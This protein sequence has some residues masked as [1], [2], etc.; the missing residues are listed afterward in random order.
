MNRKNVIAIVI[1]FVFIFI[2]RIIGI[3]KIPFPII[4]IV[5]FLCMGIAFVIT[6]KYKEDKKE[7]RYLLI[8][9]ILMTLLSTIFVIA[10]VIQNNY[11]QLSDSLKPIFISVMLILFVILLIV[12]F[13]NAA[14]KFGN[15]KS[16]KK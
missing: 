12:I 7:R 5:L 9:T 2:I 16:K 10:I 8:M 6:L 3:E 1:V 14:Y 11:T 15:N 13:A 4:A